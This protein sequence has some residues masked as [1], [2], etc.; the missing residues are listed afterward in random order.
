[1]LPSGLRLLSSKLGLVLA[2]RSSF[3]GS[4]FSQTTTATLFV[5]AIANHLAPAIHPIPAPET[6]DLQRRVADLWG[7]DAIGIS[8]DP[9]VSDDT[10]ALDHFNRMEQFVNGRYQVS[11]PWKDPLPGLHDNYGLALG[12]LRSLAKRFASDPPLSQGYAK[13]IKDPT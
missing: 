5:S 6:S 10:M 3:S 4:G 11:W 9:F 7:L 2:G 13:V 1:M 12:R 8:D